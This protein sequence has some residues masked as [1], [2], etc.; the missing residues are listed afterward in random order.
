M[1]EIAEMMLSGLLDCETGEFIDGYEPGYPRTMRH[2]Y[3]PRR[4]GRFARAKT[5]TSTP[6]PKGTPPAV[7]ANK[8]ERNRAK[9]A[10]R[11]A[12]LAA[13]ATEPTP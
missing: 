12:R 5:G 1:G 11:K 4:K 7:Y 3:P 9:K 8:T 13:L 2:A 6:T 10:R